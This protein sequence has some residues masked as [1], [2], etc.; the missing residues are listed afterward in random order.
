MSLK[1]AIYEFEHKFDD[2]LYNH[3]MRKEPFE[4]WKCW[5]QKFNR[6]KLGNLRRLIK[7]MV[8][9]TK[10]ECSTIMVTGYATT[11]LHNCG[12]VWRR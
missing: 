7:L 8:H 3:F 5:S 2:A 6:N 9:L 1:Q 12:I 10:T 4:F 11:V